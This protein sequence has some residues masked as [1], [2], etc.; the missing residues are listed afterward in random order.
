M[1]PLLG[2]PAEPLSSCSGGAGLHSTKEKTCT[3]HNVGGRAQTGQLLID[4][5]GCEQGDSFVHGAEGTV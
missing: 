2:G 4:G 1:L 3:R 5:C